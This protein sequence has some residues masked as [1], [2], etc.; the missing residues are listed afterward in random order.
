M[1][2]IFYLHMLTISILIG[3]LVCFIESTVSQTDVSSFGIFASLDSASTTSLTSIRLLLSWNTEQ[4]ECIINETMSQSIQ[5]YMC[6]TGD[7][8]P[9]GTLITD[10]LS[11]NKYEMKIELLIEENVNDLIRIETI[12]VVDYDVNYYDIDT[13]CLPPLFKHTVVHG[14]TSERIE[15]CYWSERYSYNNYAM[16]EDF[17][18]SYAQFRSNVLNYP[19]YANEGAI[20]PPMIT[21]LGIT[22]LNIKGAEYVSNFSITLHWDTEEYSWSLQPNETNKTFIKTFSGSN[23]FCEFSSGF[24]LAITASSNDTLYIDEIIIKD[25]SG[26]YYNMNMFCPSVQIKEWQRYNN[27]E[28]Q[29]YSEWSEYTMYHG[30]IYSGTTPIHLTWDKTLFLNADKKQQG[31]ILHDEYFSQYTCNSNDVPIVAP[32]AFT[33]FNDKMDDPVS[34]GWIFQGTYR[35]SLNAP[36]CP[37]GI[38]NKC[39][40]LA[41]NPGVSSID[42]SMEITI[43]VN[44]VD[45]SIQYDLTLSTMASGKSCIVYYSFDGGSFFTGNTHTSSGVTLQT[46]LNQSF[47]FIPDRTDLNYNNITIKFLN[48]ALYDNEYCYI[49]N[50]YVFVGDTWLEVD[51]CETFDSSWAYNGASIGTSHCHSGSCIQLDHENDWSLKT[52]DIN[53]YHNLKLRADFMIQG[54]NYYVYTTLVWV[55]TACRLYYFYDNG[56]DTWLGTVSGQQWRSYP[57]QMF[58]IP[59]SEICGASTLSVRFV[60]DNYRDV[61]PDCTVD[62]IVLLG[63]ILDTSSPTKAPTFN[64]STVSPTFQTLNPSSDPTTDPTVYPT[65]YPTLY[66][67]TNP[68]MYPTLYPTVDPT[69]YPTTH[70]TMYPTTD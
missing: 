23:L 1:S 17:K 37:R 3:I 41:G 59:D 53:G 36:N 63:N 29:C 54:R 39:S 65:I 19:N 48:N 18:I 49:D 12:K 33:L 45:I 43:N 62:N 28:Q 35:E 44:N 9:N 25:E 21:E 56:H 50:L 15:C 47:Q 70:P 22:T 69:M 14:T 5:Y 60:S 24:S 40:R 66:P 46:F 52:Y 11:S 31:L 55:D 16:N 10:S 68:T 32:R 27:S 38:N 30:F 7:F 42:S 34:T 57:N 51:Y 2:T 8:E 13:F 6:T 61:N 67:T 26:H 58:S 20:K 64:P 4:W